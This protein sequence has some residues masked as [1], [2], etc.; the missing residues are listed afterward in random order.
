MQIK[1]LLMMLLLLCSMAI[2]TEY[3]IVPYTDEDAEQDDPAE[4]DGGS[5]GS[6]PE[7][8]VNEAD[9]PLEPIDNRSIIQKVGDAFQNTPNNIKE[10]FINAPNPSNLAETWN[11][12]PLMEKLMMF[13]VQPE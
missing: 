12:M 13:Q 2:A 3:K 10:I 5:S 11:G 4:N 6:I 8:E 9:E 7:T 1:A